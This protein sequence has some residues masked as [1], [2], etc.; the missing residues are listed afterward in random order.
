MKTDVVS[1]PSSHYKDHSIEVVPAEFAKQLEIELERA[2]K[3]IANHEQ[4]IRE[5][6]EQ[7][8]AARIMLNDF[9]PRSLI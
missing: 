4:T 9:D 3:I 8:D 6:K 5:L 2:L 1:R 7:Y